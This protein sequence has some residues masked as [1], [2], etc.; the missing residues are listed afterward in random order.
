MTTLRKRTR[1][2]DLPRYIDPANIENGDV[3]RVA[4]TN[5]GVEHTRTAR[6]YRR[7]DE[8]PLS[9]FYTEEGYEIFHWTPGAPRQH[10][11]TLLSKEAPK[12]TSLFDVLEGVL[13]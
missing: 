10:R 3:V 11:V 2:S 8:G 9:V 6:V 13:T 12:H 5:G 4:W 7:V 1:T